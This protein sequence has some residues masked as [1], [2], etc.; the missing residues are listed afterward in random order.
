MDKETLEKRIKE[1]EELK[2]KIDEKRKEVDAELL[3]LRPQYYKF[4]EEDIKRQ[5]EEASKIPPP[6]TG[7]LNN[8]EWGGFD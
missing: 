6:D 5:K 1:L 3:Q 7:F 8:K 2:K 4:V